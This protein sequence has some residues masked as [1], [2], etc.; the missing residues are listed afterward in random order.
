[1][2]KVRAAV[3]VDDRR[4]EIQEFELPKIGPDAGLLR[5]E[6]CGMCG[7][8]VEQYDSSARVAVRTWRSCTK[9]GSGC[10]KSTTR[11]AYGVITSPSITRLRSGWLR[12]QIS[13]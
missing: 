6:A 9:S 8:D 1:M 2:A 3:Q 13:F 12:R 4:I 11:Q 10:S 5:V 7:S